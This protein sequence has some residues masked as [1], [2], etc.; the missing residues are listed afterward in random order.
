MSS[1]AVVRFSSTRLRSRMTGC[2]WAAFAQNDGP[3]SAIFF[4]MESSCWR[5]RR[6]SKVL[7]QAAHFGADRGEFPIK[8]FD[9]WVAHAMVAFSFFLRNVNKIAANEIIAQACAKR[10]P[11][12]G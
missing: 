5:R 4:S 1:S 10:S 6:G 12:R 11:L 3:A 7:L 2:A 9:G 8:L